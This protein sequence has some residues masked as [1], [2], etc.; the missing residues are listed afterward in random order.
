MHVCHVITRLI[1]GG[2]QENTLLTCEGL[3]RRGH[4]VTLI[5]G[6]D[7]GSEGT[8]WPLVQECCTRV[9][10]VGSLRRNIHPL[11][12]L[13]CVGRLAGRLRELRPQIVHTHSSK[14]GIVGRRA[15]VRAGVPGIVHTIHGMSFN[16]TQR[17]SVRALYRLLERRAARHTHALV[18][19]ADAM[20]EQAVAAGL[21]PR[22]KF[23][24]IYSGM[25]TELFRPEPE[26]RRQIRAEWGVAPNDVVVGTVARLFPNKG[27]DDLASAVPRILKQAPHC[28]FVWVGGGP[29]R[30]WYETMLESSGVRQRVRFTGLVAP[31]EIPRLLNGF[32]LLAHTSRW[33]GLP[34]AAVQA[35]LTEVPVVAYPIDGTPEVVIP[36]KT[37]LL[38]KAFDCDALAGGIVELAN[39]PNRRQNMGRYGRTLC[40]N[41]FDHETM[42]ERLEALY[43]R[44]LGEQIKQGMAVGH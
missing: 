7:T 17:R 10:R 36:D 8:L 39:A 9:V 38:V 21:A 34:R 11:D 15:A 31:A 23:I 14:A 29:R 27:Y 4:E 40:L 22:E 25:R 37:G 28:V 16:R 12:D 13:R 3:V 1:I 32:D 19:V 5:A 26:V 42:V 2:A 6:P 43:E 41:R 18:S 35:L 44:I 24:T 30:R 20:T 33:E